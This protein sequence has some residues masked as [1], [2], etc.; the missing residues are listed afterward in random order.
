M[1]I[2][3]NKIAVP[4]EH[5]QAMLEAFEKSA[6]EMKRFS[7]FLGMEIWTE[8][9]GTVLSVSRWESEEALK[10]YTDNP[11]FGKHH[12]GP[13]RGDHSSVSYYTGKVLI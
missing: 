8:Q 13:S 12:A 11:M 1:F 10:E 4:A 5:R 9:D 3:V 6:P 7:G 2:A